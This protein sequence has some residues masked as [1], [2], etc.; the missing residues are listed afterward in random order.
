MSIARS[1]AA[2]GMNVATLRLQVVGQ[3]CRQRYIGWSM[4]GVEKFQ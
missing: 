2:S 4:A 1:I 3:Q